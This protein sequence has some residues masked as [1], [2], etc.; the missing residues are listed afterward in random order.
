MWLGALVNL[1][2]SQ[3]NCFHN[4]MKGPVKAS[5]CFSW[6]TFP[7]SET[8]ITGGGLLHNAVI[9]RCVLPFIASLTTPLQTYCQLQ[10]W[11][12]SQWRR[13]SCATDS[14]VECMAAT[15]HAVPPIGIYWIPTGP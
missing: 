3:Q 7:V 1:E 13:F 11:A 4:A 6:M 9:M 2:A 10:C 8:L 15:L 14:S 12:V 5:R